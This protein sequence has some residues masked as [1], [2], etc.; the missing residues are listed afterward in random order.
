VSP[1]IFGVRTQDR[2]WVL[3][4]P[5]CILSSPKSYRSW[6][7]AGVSAKGISCRSGFLPLKADID[8][9]G[10]NVRAWAKNGSRS[11]SPD[12]QM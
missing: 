3:L 10:F 4:M 6:L 12:H 1:D 7:L 9:R 11:V 5:I 8:G 2:E